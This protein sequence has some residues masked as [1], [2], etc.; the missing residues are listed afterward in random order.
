MNVASPYTVSAEDFCQIV[1]SI[2]V[3]DE[4]DLEIL[5]ALFNLFDTKGNSTV[6]YREFLAG[7]AA[8]LV[9]EPLQAVLVLAF[10][11]YDIKGSNDLSR[12]DLKKILRAINHTASY[13][14]DKVLEDSAIEDIVVNLFLSSS[15][16]NST[17]ET[18]VDRVSSSQ[19]AERLILNESVI[20]FLDGQGTKQF[21]Q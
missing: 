1:S 14:G 11:I 8:C 4:S 16:S 10:E 13:F 9:A 19:C 15:N 17:D 7:V 6:F 12:A 20:S 21:G 3:Y 2:E 5:N 18:Q